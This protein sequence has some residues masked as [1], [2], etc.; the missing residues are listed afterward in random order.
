MHPARTSCLLWVRLCFREVGAEM[1]MMDRELYQGWRA[2]VL[3][4]RSHLAAGLATSFWVGPKN[5]LMVSCHYALKNQ[6]VGLRTQK[7][8]SLCSKLLLN[9]GY[10]IKHSKCY[11]ITYPL[12]HSFMLRTSYRHQ[13]LSRNWENSNEEKR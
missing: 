6:S 2:G 5:L 7:S 12:I 3:K 4:Q 1:S 8:Q 11:S 9:T 13:E 10:R